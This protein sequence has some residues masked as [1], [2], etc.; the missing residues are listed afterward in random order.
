MS[1]KTTVFMPRHCNVADVGKRRERRD[2]ASHEI[3][4]NIKSTYK[5]THAAIAPACTHAHSP[6]D[7]RM[8]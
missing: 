4:V 5:H 8:P 2:E 7:K 3:D 1:A 6:R